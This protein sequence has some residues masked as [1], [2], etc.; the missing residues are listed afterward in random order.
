MKFDGYDA[1]IDDEGEVVYD[2][3]DSRSADLI[4]FHMNQVER[5][6]NLVTNLEL[7]KLSVENAAQH[8]HQAKEERIAELETKAA[9]IATIEAELASQKAAY[10]TVA[11]NLL[12][13]RKVKLADNLRIITL[14]REVEAQKIEMF[15]VQSMAGHIIEAQEQEIDALKRECNLL[16]A[17]LNKP[18][19]YRLPPKEGDDDE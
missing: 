6:E 9:H 4:L 12:N 14:E 8:I 15:G 3:L 1:I 2:G 11:R 10:A 5:L 16:Y 18:G 13:Y 17:S 7:E 19:K